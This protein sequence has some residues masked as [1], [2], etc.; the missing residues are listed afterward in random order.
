M[1]EGSLSAAIHDFHSKLHN[2]EKAQAEVSP[3]TRME[4]PVK[5]DRRT[6][7]VEA[8]SI[9]YTVCQYYG[10]ETGENSFGYIASWS[11]DKELKELRASLETINKTSAELIDDVDRNFRQICKERGIDLSADKEAEAPAQ[12]PEKEAPAASQEAP[13]EQPAPA[14]PKQF[15]RSRSIRF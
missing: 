14:E 13:A 5:K 4:Q 9:S 3:G 2:Y 7:E 11:K 12:E 8:E 1:S 15:S 10:I 6:E